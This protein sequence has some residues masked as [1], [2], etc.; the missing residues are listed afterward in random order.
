MSPRGSA[1]KRGPKAPAPPPDVYVG[2]LFVSV[3]ALAL[4]CALLAMELQAYEW[5]MPGM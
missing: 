1:T 3:A 4:G 2:I 5:R